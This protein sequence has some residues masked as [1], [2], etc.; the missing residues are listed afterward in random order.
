M[1]TFGHGKHV[2]DALVILHAN[3]ETL[4]YSKG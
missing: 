2:S 4:E 3:L 1:V